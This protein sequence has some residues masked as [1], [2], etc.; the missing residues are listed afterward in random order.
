MSSPL[1]VVYARASKIHYTSCKYLTSR[2]L[3]I[4]NTNVTYCVCDVAAE[5][6]VAK[7]STWSKRHERLVKAVTGGV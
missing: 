2:G 7:V 4:S 1:L 6:V 3:T 5:L